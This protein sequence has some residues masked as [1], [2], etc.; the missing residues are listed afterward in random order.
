LGLA[1]DI[2]AFLASLYVIDILI[3]TATAVL[4]LIYL[5]VRSKHHRTGIKWHS[6]EFV[7][8]TGL[9]ALSCAAI[10]S[11]VSRF[12]TSDPTLSTAQFLTTMGLVLWFRDVVAGLKS[13]LDTFVP[14]TS[15]TMGRETAMIES[16]TEISDRGPIVA[17]E[18]ESHIAES[19]AVEIARNWAIETLKLRTPVISHIGETLDGGYDV[20]GSGVDEYV[21]T[22]DFVMFIGPDGKGRSSS[23]GLKGPAKVLR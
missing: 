15:R 13:K 2:V 18:Q 9:V 14:E 5:M 20:A 4:S 23:P 1:L 16:P 10:I 19:A 22:H 11:I 6:E 3:W 12:Q 7:I 8:R 21:V 17:P